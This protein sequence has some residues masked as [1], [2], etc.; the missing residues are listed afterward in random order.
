MNMNNGKNFGLKKKKQIQID[1]YVENK[2]NYN[3]KKL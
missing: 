3:I 2:F 1:L